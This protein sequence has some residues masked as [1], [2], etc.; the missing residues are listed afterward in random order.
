VGLGIDHHFVAVVVQQ[1]KDEVG[2]VIAIP[3]N[4]LHGNMIREWL[5]ETANQPQHTYY[6]GQK[7]IHI[8]PHLSLFIH[9]LHTAT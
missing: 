5:C 6:Y 2:I 3:G 1:G 8:A 7:P 9:P 4:R